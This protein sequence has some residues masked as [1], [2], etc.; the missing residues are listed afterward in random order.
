MLGVGNPLLDITVSADVNLLKKYN[1][2]ANNAII[3]EDSH[4]PLYTEIIEKYDAEYTAGGSAQN[5]L[6]VCQWLLKHRGASIYMGSVG[7]DN[8]SEILKVKATDDGVNVR[9]QYQENVPTGKFFCL[10]CNLGAH[11]C[12]QYSMD[13]IHKDTVKVTFYWYL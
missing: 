12:Y 4:L 8:F 2:E 11:G 10:L 1:L 9:Y 7:K 5:T 13:V 3:A 6:R